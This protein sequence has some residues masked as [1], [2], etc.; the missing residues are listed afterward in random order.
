MFVIHDILILMESKTDLTPV[1]GI[2]WKSAVRVRMLH[3]SVRVRLRDRKGI[4]N[5]YDEKVDGLPINQEF[6][7]TL[8]LATPLIAP[9][10]CWV[11]SDPS[12]SPLFG[13]CDG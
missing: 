10:I 5:V 6:A 3:A 9:G 13:P 1:S 2:G 11:R 8:A 7:L 4:K 12:R